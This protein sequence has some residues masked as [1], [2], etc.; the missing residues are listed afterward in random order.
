MCRPQ[1]ARSHPR[2]R[3]NEQD[4]RTLLDIEADLHPQS[5]TARAFALR[6]AFERISWQ[7]VL[8]SAEGTAVLTALT[9]VF[10]GRGALAFAGFLGGCALVPLHTVRFGGA[11]ASRPP[12]REDQDE[13][14]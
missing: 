6:G 5:F 10:A 1:S 3:L 14:S 8:I 13:R 11:R 2:R 7:A 9:G 4:H 12:G